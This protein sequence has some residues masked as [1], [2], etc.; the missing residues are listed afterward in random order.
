MDW[1]DALLLESGA[2]HTIHDEEHCSVPYWTQKRF[3]KKIILAID[4]AITIMASSSKIKDVHLVGYSGGGAV[5]AMVAAKRSDIASIRTVAGYMDHV[6]LNSKAGVSPLTGSLDPIRAAPRLKS[7]PQI[8]YSGK[9]D[10]RVP[11]W[12]LK[13]FR[14]AVGSSDCISLRQVNATHEEGWEKIWTRVWSK[15]PAC[16]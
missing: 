3:A 12:V 6:A 13:N 15:M 7:V 11:S 2:L 9:G 4:E 16:R 10:K 5:V 14:K 1:Q 8:H